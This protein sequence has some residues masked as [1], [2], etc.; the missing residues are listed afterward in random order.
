[1]SKHNKLGPVLGL[2]LAARAESAEFGAVVNTAAYTHPRLKLT[3]LGGTVQLPEGRW[4]VASISP[5][6]ALDQAFLVPTQRPEDASNG[7]RSREALRQREAMAGAMPL[8]HLF[9]AC[10]AYARVRGRGPGSL[11]DLDKNHMVSLREMLA[12]SP[13]PSARKAEG[14]FIFLIP[15]VPI[16]ADGPRGPR[17]DARPLAFE[18]RPLFDDGS[19]FV[20]LSDGR[21]E[22]RPID[23]ELLKRHGAAVTPLIQNQPAEAK[24]PGLL[25]Y[26]LFALQRDGRKETVSVEVI[27]RATGERLTV[28]WNLGEAGAGGPEL[29]ASWAQARA[30]GWQALSPRADAPVLR[31]WIELSKSLYAAAPSPATRPQ[32]ARGREPGR[33]TDI[34]S[35]LG[36]R[37]ALQET[38][39]LQL[40]S[41]GQ[42]ASEGPAVPLT[43][44]K[45]V[46]VKSH[47]YEELLAGK[48]GGRLPLAEVVL[49]ERLF[50]HFAKP[51]ALFAFLD[52]GAEFLARTG[53]LFTKT[54]IDD[55]L[56]RRSLRRLGLEE[57]IGRKFLASGEVFELALIAPDLFFM[58]GTDLTLLMRL[59]HPGRTATLLKE[60][61]G[62]DLRED[63]VTPRQ[64]DAGRP[65]Y[66]LRHG[67]LLLVGT[68]REELESVLALARAG[69]AGSLGKSAEFRYMVSR[70]PLTKETRAFVYLSDPFIRRMVGPEVKIGQL[71]RL[72][73]RAEME[74][75]LA[76][77]LLYRLDGGSGTPGLDTLGGLGYVPAGLAEKYRLAEDLTV[78]SPVWGT[79]AD[80]TPLG[81][82]PIDTATESEA[83]AYRAYVEEYSRYWRQYFDP[84]ALRLD[85]SPAGGLDLQVFILPLIDSQVYDQLRAALTAKPE[86]APLRTPRVEPEP[87]LLLSMNLAEKAWVDAAGRWREILSHASGISPRLFD[88]L[89][90]GFH[91]A[92]QDADPIIVLGNADILGGFGGQA[93]AGG[94]MRQGIPLLLS[95]VTRP[96]KIFLELSDE[97]AA[98]GLLR[99]AAAGAGAG[100][101]PWEAQAEMRQIDGKDA[102]ILS[103]GAAGLVRIR[104][105]LEVKDGFLIVSNNPWSQPVTV[106]GRTEAALNGAKVQVSN[107]ALRL[108]LPGLH[109]TQQEQNQASALS[110]MAY[111]LP[112]L[113]TGSATPAEA[114]S[115]HADLFGY[116]PLHPD[117]GRWVWGDGRLES[118]LYGDAARWRQPGFRADAGDFGLMR[119]IDAASVEMRFEDGGLRAVCRW[120]PKGG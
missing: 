6:G 13:Y 29:L 110:G 41:T 73:A 101:R 16:A 118:D 55:D 83:K 52:E 38:L 98:L 57:G 84:V 107:R 48:S 77:A 39:Q 50:V 115:R 85:D 70:L 56:K 21:T 22:R 114:A 82:V 10:H 20:L 30:N 104:L 99:S 80:L 65:A 34:M 43:E 46:Q 66:W 69:G 112:L 45:G 75:T 116:A 44:L 11:D 2:L 5:A 119:G 111:L 36:G 74:R 32:A 58:D 27:Q 8:R 59:A 91:L 62:V 67:D 31:T 106:K 15:D 81:A 76:G 4:E 71:R 24:L 92:V 72:E 89:G 42:P 28:R 108:A 53:A 117:G 100:G 12:Q 78:T 103:L 63:E 49:P 68:R 17:A 47:P 97:K 3:A 25:E 54:D 9:G 18:L 90:P 60:L 109:A 96:C 7:L 14:P 40:L 93:M 61:G 87:A 35:V 19:H 64:T 88:L 95:L 51:A 94:F 37:A 113:L 23:R 120:S 26:G 102:W 86:G 105:G 1:M 33:S 79:P